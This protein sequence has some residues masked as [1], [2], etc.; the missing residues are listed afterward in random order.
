MVAEP[1]QGEAAAGATW[2]S[3][4]LRVVAALGLLAI[5]CDDG[6]RRSPRPAATEAELGRRGAAFIDL[7]AAGRF[8]TAHARLTPRLQRVL[9]ADKLALV[10][11]SAVKRNGAFRRRQRVTAERAAGGG[12][13]W[14]VLV[15]ARNKLEGKLVFS[16]ERIDNLFFFPYKPPGQQP[17]RQQTAR[18]QTAAAPAGSAP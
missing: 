11:R 3:R 4:L 7:L 12:E 8:D 6:S 9:P 14:L 15:F 5:G 18:R 16:G 17:A 2:A 1:R 13:V 10:W